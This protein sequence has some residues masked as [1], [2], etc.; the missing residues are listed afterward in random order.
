MSNIIIYDGT[1]GPI[2]GSTVFG[3]YDSDI[4]FQADGPNVAKWLGNRLGFPLMNVELT[5]GSLYCAFEEA[6][7]VYGNELYQYKIKENYLSMEGNSTGS[8]WN[9][10]LITPNLGTVIRI[11]KQYGTEAGSGGQVTYRTGSFTMISG[12]Q[13][14]DLDAWASGSGITGSIEI[15]KVFYEAPP[16]IVRYFDP[17]AGTGND[18]QALLS[19]FGF[20][21]MSPG[22]NFMLMPIF[23]DV[24]KV[25]AIEFNDQVRKSAF[26]FE[27]VNNRL[28]IFPIPVQDNLQM[29][30][31]YI[32]IEERDDVVKNKATNL[33]TNIG[34]V[35]YL[36]PTYS[37]INS[38]G[39]QWIR[40]YALA[41]AKEM[42]A[43]VRGKYQTTPIP[44]AEVSLNQGDLLNDARTEKEALLTQLRLILDET[45]RKAQLERS[46]QEAT[47][48]QDT[49]NN[50]PLPIFV[51]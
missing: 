2:S 44:G 36:N 31:N 40:Q 17:Y 33:I 34:N 4:Q 26:S 42:L 15:K 32:I 41:I 27:L 9:N 11:S 10:Q 18:M 14:Y 48:I 13:E 20:G 28:R 49:L 45:S 7:T 50:I 12:K 16:A 35:P 38:I 29:F 46:S 51:G 21:A 24:L 3:F 1:A 5:T 19:S 37:F 6:V 47:F 43:Y 8:S 22:I 23:F 39:K 25:Q 30:F